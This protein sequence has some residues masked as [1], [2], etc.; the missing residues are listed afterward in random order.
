MEPSFSE[1]NYWVV[2]ATFEHGQEDQCEAFIRRGHWVMGWT[3]ERQPAM[4]GLVDRIRPGDRI[5]IKRML[6]Q[7]S[8][9]IEIRAVGIVKDVDGEN[10]CVFVDW[11][12]SGLR[13]VVPGK[14]CFATIHG[15]FS[16]NDEWTRHVFQL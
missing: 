13:R 14:G 9:D 16:A 5:A 12:V 1:P 7:G 2:G 3:R 11:V 6:G 8:A 15:P 10:L 4:A